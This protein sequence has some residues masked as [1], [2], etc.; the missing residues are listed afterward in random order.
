M[1]SLEK[2]NTG[3][4]GTTYGCCPDQVTIATG[5]NNE[6]C[7]CKYAQRCF[8]LRLY[9]LAFRKNGIRIVKHISL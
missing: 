5:P 2:S 6:G 4:L 3:C 1:S 9:V 8:S 7:S